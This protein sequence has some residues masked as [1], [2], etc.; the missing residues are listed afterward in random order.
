MISSEKVERPPSSKNSFVSSKLQLLSS[1]SCVLCESSSLYENPP[2]FPLK[3]DFQTE[4]AID[5]YGLRRMKAIRIWDGNEEHGGELM[6]IKDGR[7][8]GL[9]CWT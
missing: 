9:R 8:V 7:M 3:S 5:N 1:V 6:N 4:L 2:S